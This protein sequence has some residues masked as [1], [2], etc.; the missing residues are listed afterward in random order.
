MLNGYHL[1]YGFYRVHPLFPK[2]L[3]MPLPYALP[4]PRQKPMTKQIHLEHHFIQL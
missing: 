1:K 2:D 4:L 3:A